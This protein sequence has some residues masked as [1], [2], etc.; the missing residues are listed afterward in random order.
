MPLYWRFASASICDDGSV[1]AKVPKRMDRSVMA[2]SIGF[3]GIVAEIYL[4]LG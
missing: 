4:S 3:D 1:R 2:L